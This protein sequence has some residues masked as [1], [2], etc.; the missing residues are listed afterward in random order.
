MTKNPKL[1]FAL[2]FVLLSNV[3]F[4]QSNPEVFSVRGTLVRKTPKLADIDRN[5]VYGDPF[6]KSR[7]ENGLFG[8]E[9]E[10]ENILIRPVNY[11]SKFNG[12]DVLL[13]PV[14]PP[15]NLASATIGANFDGLGYTAVNPP[16][17]NCA[18][19]T[20]YVI[21][22]INNSSSSYFKIWN[23]AGTQVQAQTLISSL[24]GIQGAGDPVVIYDQLANRWLLT[25]FGRTPSNA[26][27]INTLIMAVSVTDDPTGSWYI[28]SFVDNTFFVDYPKFAV[29]HNA[30]YATSNDFNTAATAYLG[31]SIYAFDRAKMLLG[32]PS[33]TALRARLT[34]PGGRYFSMAPVCLEG[35]S[36]SSQSGLFGFFQDDQFTSDPLDVDSLF[37]FEFT[38]DFVVP[39]SSVIGPLTKMVTTP[40]DSE[41]CTATRGRC[42]SQQGSATALEDLTGRLMHKIIYRKFGSYEAIVTNTTVDASGTGKA[43]IRWWELRKPGANWTIYQEGTYSPDANHRWL[44]GICMDALGNIGLAYNVSGATAFPS[45]RFTGRN[46]CDPLGTMT[47]PETVII[48]GTAA[49]GSTRYGDYGT[50]T[51]DPS[52]GRDFWLTEQYN[53]ASTWST[54]LGTFRLNNCAPLPAIRFDSS[55]ITYRETDA[56]TNLTTCQK[57]KDYVINVLIDAAPSQPATVTFNTSG[58]ATNGSGRDYTISPASVILNSGTL[59]QPLTIRVFDDDAVEGNESFTISYTINN[60]GGNAVADVYNQTCLVNIIDNDAAPVSSK[61]LV[62]TWGAANVGITTSG[63]FNGA[64]Y[65]DKRV[66]NLY[67]ASDLIAA[68]FTAGNIT[69]FAWNFNSATVATFNNFTLDIGF[70]TVTTMATGFVSP[71]PA[72]TSIFSGNFNTPGA[73]GWRNFVLPTPVAWNGTDNIVIQT[74]WDNTATTADVALIGTTPNATPYSALVR[75]NTPGAGTTVCASAAVNTSTSRPDIRLKIVS[76]VNAVAS[77]L[78]TSKTANLGPNEDVYFYDATGKIM[79][80][81][82]NLTAFDYGCTQI[83]IDRAG[84]ASAQFWNNN[85]QNYLASKS[86]KVIPT[87]NTSTGHYEITLYYTDAEVTGWQS[88]TGFIWGNAQMAKVS[89]GFFV[90]DVTPGTPHSGDVSVLGTTQLA[91]GND[92]SITADFNNTGFSGFGVGIPASALPVTMVYFNGY[93]KNNYAVLEWKTAAEYNN[94]GFE[95]EKSFDGITFFNIGFVDG[96][97]TSALAHNYMFNDK[98]KLTNIQYYRLKQIDLDARAVYSNTVVLKS[99]RDVLDLLS[100]TNPFNTTINMLFTKPLTQKMNIEMYDITGKVVFATSRNPGNLSLI[101]FTVADNLSKGNYILKITTGEY[102]FVKKLVKF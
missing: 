80:R 38:P 4:S 47:L 3:L 27:F 79:A 97:G 35:T 102:Q 11:G 2:V 53:I 34:D 72:F 12:P 57:Y 94:K 43:G 8:V 90:P 26:S 16:D 83:Q 22:T 86:F 70:T 62:Q 51:I 58:T 46:P 45:I 30:Y 13:S 66:Q 99:N 19:G 48:N 100:V 84:T 78:N 77:A 40:F 15:A 20:N 9:E 59:S 63:A 88:A 93:Q 37:I 33:V 50:L 31:S 39:A 54:R 89:N 71:A 44:G 32:N 55:L 36:T 82:K 65:T 96:A 29:W 60:A 21:Q 1:L 56:I 95:L 91:Y 73:T 92:N 76:P 7:D 25:E 24:T 10:E 42:I 81:I 69:E 28:Y 67:L 5:S 87:N 14:P 17:P 98:A 61:T 85:T 41:V 68:G 6:I 49:N 23:K 64:A 52:T 18:V 75:V 101:E 74:C